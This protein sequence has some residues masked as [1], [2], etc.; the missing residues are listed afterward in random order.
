LGHTY[1]FRVQAVGVT[2]QAGP[3]SSQV[4]SV[5]P[6]RARPARARFSAGWR[7]HHVRGA[8]Q[9]Q[10]VSSTRR[11][12]IVRLRF[13][14]GSLALIGERSARGGVARVTVDHRTRTVHLH[15]R[16]TRVR[17]VIYRVRLRARTHRLTVRVVRGKVELEGVAITSRRR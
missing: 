7:V 12:A 3:W 4:T 1:T 6:S 2:G 15:A 10:T 5:V 17:Q 14:G 13:S 8:W 9:G 11:G 16:R